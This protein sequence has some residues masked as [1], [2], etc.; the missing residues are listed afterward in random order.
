MISILTFL[1]FSISR[2]I[3]STSQLTKLK[4]LG[5]NSSMTP[6]LTPA[7]GRPIIELVKGLLLGGGNTYS[8]QS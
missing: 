8:G 1:S 2:F 3:L 6:P 4:D 5:K 7:L